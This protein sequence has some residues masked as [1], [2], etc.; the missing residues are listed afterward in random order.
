MC[1]PDLQPERRKEI[2][3]IQEEQAGAGRRARLRLVVYNPAILPYYSQGAS[4]NDLKCGSVLV[5]NSY[6]GES[7]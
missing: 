6:Q 2:L 7:G 4:L 5:N 3:E 1:H